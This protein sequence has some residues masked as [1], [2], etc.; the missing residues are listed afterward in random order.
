[1]LEQPK[2]KNKSNKQGQKNGQFDGEQ[3]SDLVLL[4]ILVSLGFFG[5]KDIKVEDIPTEEILP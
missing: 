5:K 1:V 4:F 3:F 2:N